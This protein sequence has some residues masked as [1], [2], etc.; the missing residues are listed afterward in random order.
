MFRRHGDD[1]E[2]MECQVT[3]CWSD[4]WVRKEQNEKIFTWGKNLILLKSTTVKT[5]EKQNSH[6]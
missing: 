4:V 6:N 3:L 2:V 1:D 5:L